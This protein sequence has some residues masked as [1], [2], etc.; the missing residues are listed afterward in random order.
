MKVL[1]NY[2]TNKEPLWSKRL[3]TPSITCCWA[4]FKSI[5]AVTPPSLTL[6]S[7][8]WSCQ[9]KSFP[10]GLY[11][12][13]KSERSVWGEKKIYESGTMPK[14]WRGTSVLSNKG[15]FIVFSKATIFEGWTCNSHSC[16][17]SICFFKNSSNYYLISV[18]LDP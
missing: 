4:V 14:T 12:P 13:N 7:K 16:F 5:K 1:F 11:C 2:T 6:F 9:T 17:T 15:K 8:G 3:F 18:N 10:L